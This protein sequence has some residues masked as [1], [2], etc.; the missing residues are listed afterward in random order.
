MLGVG[1]PSL[2]VASLNR[3]G[4]WPQAG[5]AVL[6][7]S[8]ELLSPQDFKLGDIMHFPYCLSHLDLGSLLPEPPVFSLKK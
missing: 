4:R 5:A 8:V 7:D 2:L 6:R 3:E 1:R